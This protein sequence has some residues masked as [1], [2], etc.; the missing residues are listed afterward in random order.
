V[1]A[2]VEPVT[3]AAGQTVAVVVGYTG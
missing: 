1:A 2:L 3:A